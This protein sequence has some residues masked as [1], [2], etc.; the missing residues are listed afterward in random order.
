MP[1]LRAFIFCIL[2]AQLLLSC[3]EDVTPDG[4]FPLTIEGFSLASSALPGG[5][6]LTDGEWQHTY[7]EKI[8]LVFVS[9][10]TGASLPFTFEPDFTGEFPQILLPPDSYSY[11][12]STDALRISAFLPIT[13]EGNVV[14]NGPTRT[15]LSGKTGYQLVSFSKENLAATSRIMLPLES[16]LF[17][18]EGYYYAYVV[19]D[20]VFKAELVLQNG[21][22]LNW[23]MDTRAFAHASYLFKTPAGPSQ[24]PPLSDPTLDLTRST[25]MLDSESV[26]DKMLPFYQTEL[27]DEVPE[28]S[29][30]Q[31]VGQ[32]LYAINDGGNAAEIYGID[33]YHGQMIRRIRVTN[34]PNIDWE[35][36]A[37]DG[38]Y[39]YIGDFGNNLGTRKDLRVLRISLHEL[40]TKN[41]VQAE[42]IHFTYDRQSS[43]EMSSD[44][45]FDC[46]AMAFHEGQLL[47]F[48][49]PTNAQGSDVYTLD[50]NPGVQTAR[51]AGTFETKGW[52]TGADITADGKNLVF[53]GYENAGFTSQSFLGLIENPQL[54]ALSGNPLKT[55]QLGSLAA[56][57]QTEG[58]SID[59]SLR[60]KIAGEQINRSGLSIPQ[61]LSELDLKG[62]LED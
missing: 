49:K 3:K 7:G 8:S 14:V 60:V 59:L 54:P 25:V 57:G 34:A 58:I 45:R 19:P 4:R 31:F 42:T 11:S 20:E 43:T 44:H 26:P 10:T 61:R 13:V 55:I 6:L 17:S 28:A 62:I 15:L 37:S 27:A 56:N 2:F 5:R 36:L 23:G 12:G 35:D 32:R 53:V 38:Q 47:L 16:P 1:Q 22:K 30:L 40:E 21:N 18:N 50:A 24:T 33:L 9:Q 52:I 41:E 46:E 51:F 48:T 29:G 39:L